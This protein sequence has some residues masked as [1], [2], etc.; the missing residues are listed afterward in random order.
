MK[1]GQQQ[2]PAREY[3]WLPELASDAGQVSLGG[4]D[5]PPSAIKEQEL[6]LKKAPEIFPFCCQEGSNT[7]E[8]LQQ[9]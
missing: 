4:L 3:R 7:A 1:T 8:S 5:V 6:D 9:S 2:R